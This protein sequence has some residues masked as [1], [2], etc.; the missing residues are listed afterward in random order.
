[1]AQRSRRSPVVPLTTGLH[2]AG[3]AFSFQDTVLH[4]IGDGRLNSIPLGYNAY[5]AM[6]SAHI[7]MALLVAGCALF[8]A[9]APLVRLLAMLYPVLALFTVIVSGNHY[10]LDAAGGVP[11]ASQLR[12]AWSASSSCRLL[13]TPHCRDTKAG[14]K[15]RRSGT[16]SPRP[17]PLTPTRSRQRGCT[18]PR[19]R[20]LAG[21]SI[22]SC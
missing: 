10:L 15:Q 21:S 3:H 8:L 18:E 22:L 13:H 5:A 7:A 4:V 20:R 6:P 11:E 14:L 17:P 2:Y 9:R 19:A 16:A 12:C 1:V